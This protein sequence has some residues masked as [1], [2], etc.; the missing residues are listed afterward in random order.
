[1]NAAIKEAYADFS[2]KAPFDYNSA[3]AYN[4]LEQL[5]LHT[6]YVQAALKEEPITPCWLF[7]KHKE[8][9][10]SAFGNLL[11]KGLEDFRMQGC[12]GFMEWDNIILLKTISTD[13]NPN[14][15]HLTNQQLKLERIYSSKRNK[16]YLIPRALNKEEED[17]IT[18]W[19]NQL[20][21]SMDFKIAEDKFFAKFGVPFKLAYHKSWIQ[22]EDYYIEKGFK[23]YQANALALSVIQSIVGVDIDPYLN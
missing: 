16:L 20:W 3:Y 7:I 19:N 4:N 2:G 12:S 15:D 21:N 18:A 6:R 23:K 22:L 9:A 17:K 14:E 1:M 13:L 11:E 8:E 5:I 10:Y